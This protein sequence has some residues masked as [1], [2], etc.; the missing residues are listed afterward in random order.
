RHRVFECAV[1]DARD[2]ARAA[3][4]ARLVLA[5]GITN[6]R[7]DYCICSHCKTPIGRKSVWAR[8]YTRKGPDRGLRDSQGA[9]TPL[10]RVHHK[11]YQLS[12]MRDGASQK[13]SDGRS[14]A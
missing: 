4:A 13:W 5:A 12:I 6:R 11:L 10:G 7:G 14:E 8:V 1:D 3:R 9:R 2:E